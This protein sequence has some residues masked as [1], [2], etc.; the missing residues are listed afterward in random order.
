MH[1]FVLAVA[2]VMSLS[3]TAAARRE[4]AASDPVSSAGAPTRSP[5]A[6]EA[7]F[8][9]TIKPFLFRN[10][11]QCHNER[12]T[13]GN[14]DLKK[15]ADVASVLADPNTWEH[16]LLKIR[17]GEM[18][19]EDEPRPT[20]AEL[21]L[22]TA[23]VDAQI[24]RAD[25]TTPPDPGR[26]TIRRLNRTEYNNTVRDLLGV[27]LKPADDF[28]QDDSGYGFDNIADV[29]SLP[30]VLMER[31]LV[32]AERVTRAALFG[33]PAIRPTL[34]RRQPRAR[35]VQPVEQPPATYDVTG[36]SLP[37][38]VHTLYRF[39]ADGE[40]AFRVVTGGTRPAAS[41]PI[42]LALWIDGRQVQAGTLDPDASA[43]FFTHKQDLGGK[44][45]DMRVRVRAGE[46]W[47]AA[48]VA[49]LFEGLPSP[50]GG[51]NPSAKPVPILVFS[52]P[53]D[54]SPE[55]L[56]R[57]RK[58]FAEQQAERVPANDARVAAIEIGGPYAQATAPAAESLAR[59]FVCGHLTGAHV[60]A[61]RRRIVAHMARRA[62]RRPVTPAEVATYVGLAALAQRRG[63]RFEEG[64]AVA[65]QAMLVAPDFLFR[66]ERDRH[67][68][69]ASGPATERRQA[70]RELDPGAPAAAATGAPISAHELAARLS[71]FL[72]ASMPDAELRRLADRGELRKPVVLEREVR[73]MLQDDRARTLVEEFGGQWLQVRALESAA[74]DKERFPGFDDYLRFS[75]RRETELFFE[76]IV[77]EDRSIFDF[78]GA[79]Y[80]FLNER[81]A[82]HYGVDGVSG[83]DFQRVDVPT[84]RGGVLTHASVLTVSSYATRTSPVLRGKWILENLLGAPPPDPPPGVANLDEATA[85]TSATLRK[86]LEAHRSDLTCA[87]CH[88]R[89]DPLGF[90]LENYDAIGAWR[91][92][93]AGMPIDAAGELPDGRAFD[94]PVALRSILEREQE[95][96]ARA[97]TVKLL[98]YALGRGLTPADRQTVRTIA[99]ALP[100]HD[101]RFS[102]LVLEIVRSAPF[103]RRRGTQS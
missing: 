48:S 58:Q 18:P 8:A 50:Y 68:A 4:R 64:L 77:R 59:I 24:L 34:V 98:T 88:R 54:A 56:E 55:R 81:L 23:W 41:A 44:F 36:L 72:W 86:Q 70:A 39:P 80:T 15:Y 66:I 73:R 45:V 63:E 52:P 69:P 33:V 20:P 17:T 67:A 82:R 83:P 62:F 42:E 79:P 43:S 11:Y 90:G 91:T 14:L 21:R 102:G 27:D 9:D 12:R 30:P 57:L 53:A 103:Q 101:Y 47:V 46:H 19:P 22:V 78:L 10:C 29:L 84:G 99:R 2:C 28:P 26:V 100:A 96:F 49:R 32:A 76:S 13:K 92:S 94:G 75:M 6:E 16:V 93:D 85:G 60:P 1:R 5:T 3:V 65:I 38:A 25:R 61:C 37:N 40:Y 31:Y 97:L 51:P 35:T 74:P 95:A 89:M 87:A 71:Y 7:A